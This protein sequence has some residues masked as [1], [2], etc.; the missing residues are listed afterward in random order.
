MLKQILKKVIPSEILEFRRKLMSRP[1]NLETKLKEFIVDDLGGGRVAPWHIGYLKNIAPF[2]K[3]KIVLEIGG[4]CFPRKLL[5]S[6][7]GAKKWVCIDYLKNWGKDFEVNRLNELLDNSGKTNDFLVF[8]LD[9]AENN[10]NA[11]DYLKFHG[12]AT[13]IPESFYGK[14]D[15]VVSTN[16]FEHILTLPQVIEKIY[17]CLKRGGKLFTGFGP[18]WSCAVG[19]HYAG[20]KYD[21]VLQKT[22]I[23]FNNIE[24]DGVPPFIHLLKNE[25]ETREYFADK[26]LPFGQMQ[27]DCLCKWSYHTDEINRLFFEDYEEIMANSKF[28]S[29]K[30]IASCIEKSTDELLE[31]LCR[32]YPKYKRFD[33]RG[34]DIFAIK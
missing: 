21:R 34:I 22:D 15:I 29:Y 2:V 14:F 26:S 16:A 19:H 12:D 3:G 6:T 10:L 27:I 24:K 4:S 28:K 13:Y 31:E 1:S 5:F 7:L 17:R 8:S 32:K 23:S 25:K 20:G 30:I 33:V 11:C 18:I 9:N